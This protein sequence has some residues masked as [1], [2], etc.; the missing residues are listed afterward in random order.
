MDETLTSE[1]LCPTWAFGAAVDSA[2]DND[3]RVSAYLTHGHDYTGYRT[4]LAGDGLSGFAISMDGDL[5]SVFNV[6]GESRGRRM[7]TL[8]LLDGAYT[9][10]CFDGYLP[11]FY[12]QFGFREVRR[13]ANWNEG[14]PDVV[15][16]AR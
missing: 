10:D 3:E 14:G 4:Y 2:I 11:K 15:Y 12:A 9:L 6:S 13:E 7:M 1:S 5:Q 8:A 16:M